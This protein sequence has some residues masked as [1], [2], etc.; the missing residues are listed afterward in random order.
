M[1]DLAFYNIKELLGL[2]RTKDING[3][4]YYITAWGRKTEQGLKLS[5]ER[6]LEGKKDQK[7]NEV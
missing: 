2:K 5:I 1:T 3:N 4:F 6:V 7:L